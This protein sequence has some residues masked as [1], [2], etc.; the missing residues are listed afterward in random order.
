MICCKITTDF[1][2]GDFNKLFGGLQKNGALLWTQGNLFFGSEELSVSKKTVE[3]I[4]KKAGFTEFFIKTYDRV[5]DVKE[6]K[7][8][9][10]WLTDHIVK[11]SIKTAEKLQQK[12]FQNLAQQLDQFTDELRAEL[13]QIENTEE[14]EGNNNG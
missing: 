9:S 11:I 6:D 10:G 7:C 2:Q 4:L 5:T 13:E 14:Q 8:V 1:D 12:E 3:N